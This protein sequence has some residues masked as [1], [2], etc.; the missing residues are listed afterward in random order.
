M[1]DILTALGGLLELLGPYLII[2]LAAV[3]FVIV[4]TL[5]V[6]KDKRERKSK[7]LPRRRYGGVWDQELTQRTYTRKW[8]NTWI[9]ETYTY[10]PDDDEREK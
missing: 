1:S 7:G 3:V 6:E 8:G 2:P 9:S 10:H 4:A 5:W